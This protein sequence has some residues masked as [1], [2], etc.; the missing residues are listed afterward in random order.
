MEV[1]INMFVYA[2]RW[3]IGDFPLAIKEGNNCEMIGF[4]KGNKKGLHCII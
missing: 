4:G 1:L 2:A 3:T